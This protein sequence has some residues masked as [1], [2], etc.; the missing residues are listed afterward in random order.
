MPVERNFDKLMDQIEALREGRKL[1]KEKVQH[2]IST[3]RWI[4]NIEDSLHRMEFLKEK[5]NTDKYDAEIEKFRK[6][7]KEAKISF[8]KWL[9]KKEFEE[10][11][12]EM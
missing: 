6:K 5:Y 3:P 2:E 11:N 9:L 12:N 7:L 1:P 10:E 4:Q 8:E